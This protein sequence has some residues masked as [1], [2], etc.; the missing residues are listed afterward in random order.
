ML[1]PEGYAKYY[2]KKAYDKRLNLN[3]PQDFN[4][5]I[6]WLKV[7]SD[8]TQWTELADKYKVREYVEQCGL[9]Q[10][11]TPLYGVWERAEDI[12]FKKLPNRF[13][14]KTNHGYGK[15]ILVHDKSQLDIKE[16]KSI[17]SKWVKEKYGL[18]SFEPHYWNIPRKIIAEEFLHDKSNEATSLVDYKFFCINGE[19][20]IIKVMKGRNVGLD[21]N[22]SKIS[23]L[24]TIT[25][26]LNWN[27]RAD[28]VPDYP[29]KVK[30]LLVPKPRRF[31]EM[32]A[33][34][35]TLSKP[36]AFVRVDLYEVNGKVYFGEL[37]FTPGGRRNFTEEYLLELGSKMDLSTVK[38][39][40]KRFII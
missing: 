32:I 29:Q 18:F 33:I 5:K 15:I 13:V 23:N 3:N 12:D 25:V 36:F 26:D 16:A 30:K 38:R 8:T 10:F 6:Q 14:L 20:E 21:K 2:Y 4:E 40:S 39:R 22:K 11:L 27:L 9:G 28:L 19:P 35:K 17:L 7:Y 34:S 1:F 24:K 31:N 37:T